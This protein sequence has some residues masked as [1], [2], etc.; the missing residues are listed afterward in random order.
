MKPLL[1][2]LLAAACS[3]AVFAAD[4]VPA[5]DKPPGLPR[6]LDYLV[7]TS[8]TWMED[9]NCA[10]CHHVTMTIWSLREA[11]SAGISYDAKTLAKTIEW[12]MSPPVN[13]TTFPEKREGDRARFSLPAGYLALALAGGDG[14]PEDWWAKLRN[15]ALTYQKP[16]GSWELQAGGRPPIL[17]PVTENFTLVAA[18]ALAADHTRKPDAKVSAALD[19]AVAW[20]SAHPATEET[21]DHAMRLLLYSRLQREPEAA[22]KSTA[23]LREHQK[24]DGGWP[25]TPG[26]PSDAHGTG[27]AVVALSASGAPAGDPAIQRARAFLTKTQKPDGSWPMGSRPNGPGK[28]PAS[29]LEP[30]TTTG[31]AWGALALA[32]TEPRK[33]A[34]GEAPQ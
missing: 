31:T 34:G 24:E 7:K 13:S 20:L 21:Q 26:A 3:S 16:D 15:D 8:N 2:T 5:S 14:V 32:R 17:T 10:T 18:N 6:A 19:K 11:A 4:P 33:S 9:H 12:V 27:Q 23:W 25:Q 22:K 30:I 29:K 1:F 28:G